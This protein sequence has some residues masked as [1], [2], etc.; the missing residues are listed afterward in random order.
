M[1]I[2]NDIVDLRENR[3]PHPRFPRRIFS[4][5]ELFRYEQTTPAEKKAEHLWTAWAAKE[6]AYKLEKQR[7]QSIIFSPREFEVDVLL[8]S[9]KWRGR[10]HTFHSFVTTDFLHVWVGEGAAKILSA[11]SKPT[12]QQES[13]WQSKAVRTLAREV[14]VTELKM[15]SARI[16]FETLTGKIPR[17]LIDL[18]NSKHSDLPDCALSFSHDGS[19]VAVA[20][21]FS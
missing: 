10:S 3:H 13:D 2:G 16:S 11:W 18:A 20:V 4:D 9:V 19:Y 6:S 8:K 5:S 1:F 17:V 21:G 7:D 15:E 12:L 14:I